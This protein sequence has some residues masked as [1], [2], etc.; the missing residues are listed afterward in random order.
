VKWMSFASLMLCL[1]VPQTVGAQSE[2][3]AEDFSQLTSEIQ[4]AIEAVDTERFLALFGSEANLEAAHQ[5]VA[6]NLRGSL[7]SL[8]NRSS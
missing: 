5:F 2:V 8:P 7:V 3:S 6:D 4:A 1:F